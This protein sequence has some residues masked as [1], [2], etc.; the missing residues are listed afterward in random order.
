[1]SRRGGGRGGLWLLVALWF[2]TRKAN[3]SPTG[4]VKIT[5]A[6]MTEGKSTTTAT[7]DQIDYANEEPASQPE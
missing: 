3:S 2:I 5:S 1:M 7:Q 4:D 6:S